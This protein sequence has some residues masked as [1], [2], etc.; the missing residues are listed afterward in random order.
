MKKSC[1]KTSR[2]SPRLSAIHQKRSNSPNKKAPFL[3]VDPGARMG[4]KQSFYSHFFLRL[5]R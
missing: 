5:I 3:R 1:F 2:N 4:Q